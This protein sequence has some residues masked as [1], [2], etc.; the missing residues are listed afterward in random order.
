MSKLPFQIIL[1]FA[2]LHQYIYIIS[3]RGL[4]IPLTVSI[5]SP[6]KTDGRPGAPEPARDRAAE[7]GGGPGRACCYT[8]NEGYLMPTLLSASQLRRSLPAGV[9]DV[10]VI[11]F[12]GATALTAA[13][14]AFCARE[15][16]RFVLAPAAMLGE[17]SMLC[18]RF[19]LGDLLEPH[20]REIVYLDGDTQVTGS[21]EPLLSHAVAPGEVLAAPDPMAVMIDSPQ[22]PWPAR[23]AYFERL[24]V[25]A[26]RHALYF[27]SG[28][29]RFRRD[30]WEALSRECLAL[31]LKNGA[32][33]EFRDQDALNLVV[34]DRHRPM[35]F[36][37]NFPPFFLNF[38]A[39]A[40]IA[41]RVYHFMS[42]PRPWHGAFPPWGRAWHQPYVAF[43]AENPGLARAVPRLG[44]LRTL[45]YVAQQRVKGL[46]EARQWGVPAVRQ[47]I[48][49]MEAAAVV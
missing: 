17:A 33:F 4:S 42:N 16:I 25:P 20:Y 11:C 28:V 9:A 13:A 1:I 32:D 46:L 35:S 10:V 8:I 7:P 18:A 36:R 29:M 19:F 22:A 5:S 44:R 48:A 2:A 41:P 43:L 37:W 45:R 15:A 23:R 40:A 6:A 21:L 39:Q 30:D 34:G 38:G 31:C 24:G 14:E 12:G 26:H 47:R 49:A 27:N 3:Q